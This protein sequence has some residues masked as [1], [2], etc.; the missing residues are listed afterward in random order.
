MKH[1][2]QQQQCRHGVRSYARFCFFAQAQ[3]HQPRET[4]ANK[5]ENHPTLV[6]LQLYIR[7]SGFA[8][9][10]VVVSATPTNGSTSAVD[11]TR[12]ALDRTTEEPALACPEPELKV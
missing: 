10:V 9:V 11:L 12:V 1:P 8:T 7:T 5:C 6:V 4:W 3:V 2:S